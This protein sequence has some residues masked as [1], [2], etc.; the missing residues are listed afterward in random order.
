MLNRRFSGQNFRLYNRI[1]HYDSEGRKRSPKETRYAAEKQADALR[2]HGLNARV[3]NWVGGSGV[4]VAPSKRYQRKISESL[5]AARAS[6][7]SELMEDEF[8][9]MVFGPRGYAINGGAGTPIELALDSRIG[10]EK[11]LWNVPDEN[12]SPIFSTLDDAILDSIVDEN[13]P[14]A[15][16]E[17][18]GYIGGYT[19]LALTADM[20][21][22]ATKN[23]GEPGWGPIEFDSDF[24]GGAKQRMPMPGRDD[25]RRR[26]RVA[27]NFLVEGED[28]EFGGDKYGENPTYA[29]ATKEAAEKFARLLRSKID[30]QGYYF[31]TGGTIDNGLRL[32]RPDVTIPAESIE[33]DVVEE[34]SQ[35]TNTREQVNARDFMPDQ[36]SVVSL[37]NK[38]SA[39]QKLQNE[40]SENWRG[41]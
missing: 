10:G 34:E 17:P 30:Q 2:D 22:E 21:D 35:M 38:D 39:Q 4:F 7:V 1:G 8:E 6:W 26:Y 25:T 37:L 20:M 11:P 3:V 29:F 32:N 14:I 16:N 36:V 12:D 24:V 40:L 23:G 18:R 27:M 9:T 33:I 15:S 13:I 28:E 31:S 19:H 5:R 41:F